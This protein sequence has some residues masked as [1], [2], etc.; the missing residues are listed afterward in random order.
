VKLSDLTPGKKRKFVLIWW[1][2]EQKEWRR[3][4]PGGGSSF[5]TKE[6]AAELFK[7]MRLT[8]WQDEHFRKI[9]HLVGS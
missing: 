8:K 2:K 6:Q 4:L 9:Y 5:I 3:E 7:T 1:R